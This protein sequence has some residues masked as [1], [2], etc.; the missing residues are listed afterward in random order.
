MLCRCFVHDFLPYVSET[1]SKES[2]SEYE[3]TFI[4]LGQKVSKKT[5]ILIYC[6]KIIKEYNFKMVGVDLADILVSLYRTGLKSYRWYLAVFSQLLDISVNNAFE[7]LNIDLNVKHIMP[8]N[9]LE[10]Q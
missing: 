3:E 9:N 4:G 10:P 5:K 2:F 1:F 6:T 8:L 7:T